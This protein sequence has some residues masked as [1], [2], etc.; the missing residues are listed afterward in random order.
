MMRRQRVI[1]MDALLSFS[2]RPNLYLFRHA[3]E[4]IRTST[5]RKV[6]GSRQCLPS[7]IAELAHLAEND[8][9]CTVFKNSQAPGNS[10]F[11]RIGA[12]RSRSY[13]GFSRTQ[14]LL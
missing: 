4:S 14:T 6:L 7:Y 12:P 8:A 9:R 3:R 13:V 2:P 11:L 10:F 5:S 1:K